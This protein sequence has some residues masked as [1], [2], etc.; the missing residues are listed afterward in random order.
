MLMLTGLGP[1]FRLISVL[2]LHFLDVFFNLRFVGENIGSVLH[3]RILDCLP[4]LECIHNLNVNYA[5]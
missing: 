1:S 3:Q 5:K 2:Q 4:D